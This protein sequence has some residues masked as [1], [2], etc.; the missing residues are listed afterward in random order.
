MKKK[1]KKPTELESSELQHV[2]AHLPPLECDTPGPDHSKLNLYKT[3][4]VPSR[5]S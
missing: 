1:K 2:G 4:G 5:L 3:E